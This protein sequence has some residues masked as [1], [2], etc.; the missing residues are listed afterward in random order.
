MGLP[1]KKF[2]FPSVLELKYVSMCNMR[3]H[4]SEYL[5]ILVKEALSLD[6]M[7]A[8]YFSVCKLFDLSETQL[9][10]LSWLAVILTLPSLIISF[11]ES[12]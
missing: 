5:K 6:Y 7:P 9:T 8:S 10:N 2:S 11:G 12:S 1:H 4:V 3:K